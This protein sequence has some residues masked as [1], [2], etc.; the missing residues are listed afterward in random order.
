MNYITMN[1]YTKYF[2]ALAVS[3]LALA[4]CQP[5]DKF[6]PDREVLVVN[7]VDKGALIKFPVEAAP[8]TYP[9]VINASGP[10]AKDVKVKIAID[11]SLVAAYN[12]KNI[13]SYAALPESDLELS[14]T[15]VVIPAGSTS[16]AAATLTVKSFANFKDG[17]TYV[18]PVTIVSNDGGMD[19]LPAEKTIYLRISR[20]I[21]HGSID[22]NNSNFS[23]TYVFSDDLCKSMANYTFE[24]KIYP[25]SWNGMTPSLS[26]LCSFGDKNNGGSLLYRFGEKEDVDILQVKTP[27]GEL[28]STHK[29][30]T[31]KWT[32]ISVVYNGSN[33]A[34]F[35]DGDKDVDNASSN[36]ASKWQCVEL[37]M[38]WT[39]YRSAQLYHGRIAELRVWDR[40]L[41]SGE[42]K[43]GLCGVPSD[44]EGLVAYFKFDEPS[45]T[46]FKDATGHGYD[47]D[48]AKSVR[49]F[50]DGEGNKS[51]ADAANYINRVND[52]KNKCAN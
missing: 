24:I 16:S 9:V 38:S 51:N 26:R 36:E 17:T 8:A 46:V 12:E 31:N 30:E 47:M 40:A 42:I 25:Y 18:V 20:T 28:V 52:E 15:E 22:M 10:V 21:Q 49:E 7:G 48:W 33:I 11:N 39:T 41:T 19:I 45:G 4:A 37:G 23:S 43:A 6:D 35:N 27:A 2:F 3:C 5:G 44:S 32:M 34:L 50:V 14:T 1:K 29:Y 13:A